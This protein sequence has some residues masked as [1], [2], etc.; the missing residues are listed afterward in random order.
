MARLVPVPRRP[1]ILARFLRRSIVREI[2]HRFLEAR[3]II[4][5]SKRYFKDVSAEE[6][7]KIFNTPHIPPAY[8]IFD[9]AVYFTPAFLQFGPMCR[10]AMVLHESI[11]VIDSESGTKEAHISEWDEPGFADQTAEESVHNPSAYAS[12]GAQVY[13]GKIEWPREVRYGAGRPND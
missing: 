2:V 12:F 9:Q 5:Q 8:A 6:A 1:K 13:E 11:H 10:A 3:R 4:E 7:E